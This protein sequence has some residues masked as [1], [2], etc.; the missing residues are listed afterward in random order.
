MIRWAD[1]IQ[2]M[3]KRILLISA[4][5]AIAAIAFWARAEGPL[6]DPRAA[7][8]DFYH[9]D[10]RAEDQLADPLIRTGCHAAALVARE[11]RDP[12]MR[13]RRYA[14]GYLGNR[15]CGAAAPAL[16]ALLINSAESEYIRGDALEAIYAINPAAGIEYAH[17]YA[18]DQNYLGRRAQAILRR[19]PSVGFDR[20]YWEAVRGVHE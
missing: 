6:R 13:Q 17:R 5:V 14:I 2:R 4:A 9:S 19:D 10:G 16:H 3:R 1:R 8:N 7:L 20:S 18:A 15:K 11:I 12:N